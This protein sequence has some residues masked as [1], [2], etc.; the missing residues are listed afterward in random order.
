MKSLEEEVSDP[1][2]LGCSTVSEIF[3][4]YTISE[5]A[6]TKKASLEVV[7]H[8]AYRNGATKKHA[9]TE[10][11]FVSVCLDLGCVFQQLR[12]TKPSQKDR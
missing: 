3:T 9:K 11:V 12:N 2:S 8:C 7:A 5:K 10:K 4:L 1:R 6:K